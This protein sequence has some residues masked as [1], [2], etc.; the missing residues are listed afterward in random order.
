MKDDQ[1]NKLFKYMEKRFDEMD[2]RFD[3]QDKKIDAIYNILDAHLKKIE[4]I[5]I[6]NAAR[7]RQ[8]ERLEK[9]VFQIA[10]KLDI[11]LKYDS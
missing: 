8:Q 2:K 11:K 1:F 9:W 7:D 4:D 6:E 3:A 5:L 10:D